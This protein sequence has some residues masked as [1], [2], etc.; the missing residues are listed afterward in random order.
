MRRKA[1][2]DIVGININNVSDPKATR[3]EIIDNKLQV[4]NTSIP[5]EIPLDAKYNYYIRDNLLY[6]TYKS[7]SLK[8][9]KIISPVQNGINVKYE[10]ENISTKPQNITIYIENEFSPDYIEVMTRGRGILSIKQESN[11]YFIFNTATSIGVELEPIKGIDKVEIK[12]GFLGI[13]LNPCTKILLPDAKKII[14][15]FN[16]T[17]CTNIS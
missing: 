3:Q 16:L 4:S 17:R 10:I 11:R 5:L 6:F 7:G 14:V 13:E 1:L 2:N 12:E 9:Q 15:E 8:I